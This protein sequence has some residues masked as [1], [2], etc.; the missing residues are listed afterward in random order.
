MTPPDPADGVTGSSGVGGAGSWPAAAR[1]GAGRW[2]GGGGG[3]GGGG[4]GRGGGGGPPP[5]GAAGGPGAGGGGG[6]GAGAGDGRRGRLRWIRGGG[7]LGGRCGREVLGGGLTCGRRRG[8]GCLRGLGL[9]LVGLLGATG[10]AGRG[11]L[12]LAAG[13]GDDLGDRVVHDADRVHHA[14]GEGLLGVEG[15]ALAELRL[16]HLGSHAAAAGHCV[17]ELDVGAV[18]V[19]LDRVLGLVGQGLPGVRLDLV[20]AGL[21]ECDGEARLVP[22]PALVGVAGPH[23]DGAGDP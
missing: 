21:D 17:D 19:V 20:L 9:D 12:G 1:G 15:A 23:A 14:D 5:G 8:G 10:P 2:C 22:E 18:D 13:Q 6:G 4:V 11:A 7:I 3:A 16:N